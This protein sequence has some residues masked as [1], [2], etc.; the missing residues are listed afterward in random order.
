MKIIRLNPEFILRIFGL[1]TRTEKGLKSI[2]MK[3]ILSF[4]AKNMQEEQ[5]TKETR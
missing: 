5:N 1:Q 4:T 2:L 3:N